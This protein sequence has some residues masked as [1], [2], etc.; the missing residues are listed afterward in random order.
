M[1][2]NKSQ[3]KCWYLFLTQT[4]YN[5]YIRKETEN[6]DCV[7][8]IH[9]PILWKKNKHIGQYINSDNHLNHIFF[10]HTWYIKFYRSSKAPAFRQFQYKKWRWPK[11]DFWMDPE[12]NVFHFYGFTRPTLVTSKLQELVPNMDKLKKALDHWIK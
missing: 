7:N 8:Q 3:T 4:Y 2:Y 6:K 12:I 10:F 5:I 1:I 11:K 9:V